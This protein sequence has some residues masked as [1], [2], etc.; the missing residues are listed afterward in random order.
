MAGFISQDDLINQITTNSKFWRADWNKLFNPTAAAV[1]G[2][3]H[4]MARG[5]GNPTADA[6]FNAGT[7]LVPQQVYDTTASAGTIPNGGYVDAT[8]AT[9]FK[10]CLNA[11]AYS[12][13]ATTMP[14]V[15]MLVDILQFYRVTAVA[16]TTAQT[17]I[18][19]QTFTASS[20]TGLL[21]TYVTD[22]TGPITCVRFTNSGGALPTGLSLNTSYWLVRQSATTAKVSTSLVNAINN[23]FVAFTDAGTGTNTFTAYLPRYGT[24]AGVQ[25]I[26]FNSNATALGAGTPNLTLSS[27]T[28]G[29]GTAGRVTPALPSP[30]VG[31]TGATNSHILYSGATAAGKF[32]PFV[33]LQSG[34][35]GIRSV[36][37]IQN[38]TSYVSGEY[39]VALVKPLFSLPLTTLGVAGEREFGSM[40]PSYPR[41]YDGAALYWLYYSGAATPANSAF[42]GHLDLGWS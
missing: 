7:A 30:P 15:M 8:A 41:V 19:A 38:S 37:S 35:T 1:A 17:T 12:A 34:D 22:W 26:F 23:V 4:S 33:P 18:N 39:S 6:I 3:W 9:G 13:A 20:S 40:L 36:E 14:G 29:A 10:V 32:G 11:A 28:N 5:G 42:Y 24:G 31:K 2:E 16:T 25:S 21:L 27:Y